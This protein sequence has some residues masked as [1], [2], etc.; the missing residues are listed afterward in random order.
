MAPS[1]GTAPGPST[2][3]ATALNRS[4]TAP[5]PTTDTTPPTNS[6]GTGTGTSSTCTAPSGATTLAYDSNGNQS[7]GTTYTPFDQ[8]ATTGGTT[9]YSYAGT[10]NNQRLSYAGTPYT[11]SLIS[12]QTTQHGISSPTKII[13]EPSG[14][15]IAYQ[16]GGDSYYYI[17]DRQSSVVL[18]TGGPSNTPALAADYDYT[19]YG[20]T[21]SATG[22]QATFNEYRYT[23]TFIDITS[24]GLYKMGARYYNQDTGRFT[25]PDPSGQEFNRYNYT[26]SNPVS[27]LL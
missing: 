16:T 2:R 9:N 26:S 5:P 8:Q 12:N 4:S 13:R 10:T 17:T 25:Q 24:T 23:G 22:A 3:T 7:T 15:L 11:P 14:G 27:Y 18:I 21:I 6:A 20:A 1:P 19:P